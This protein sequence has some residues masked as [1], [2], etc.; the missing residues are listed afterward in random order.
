M[1]ATRRTSTFRGRDSPRTSTV[2]SWTAENLR[3]DVEA[4]V[5]QFVQEKSAAVRRLELPA[6]IAGGPGERTCS[7]TK[8]NTFGELFWHGCTVN[9]D[10]R[11]AGSAAELVDQGG[12][13]FLARSGLPEDQHRDIRCRQQ[14]GGLDGAGEC[15]VTSDD[16]E[17]LEHLLRVL[18]V[19]VECRGSQPLSG[20][21]RREVRPRQV[22][23]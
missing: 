4:Q 20:A 9:R 3:L 5:A 1:A 13:E 16:T 23:L 17:P 7:V 2:P 21:D 12:N 15:G 19:A 8:Q 18:D 22:H 6:L 11:A 10:E 14:C